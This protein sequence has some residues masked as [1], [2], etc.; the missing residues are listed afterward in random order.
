MSKFSL[1][2]SLLVAFGGAGGMLAA[3]EA[4]PLG[5]FKI[6]AGTLGGDTKKSLDFGATFSFAV[7]G[8]YALSERGALVGELG[9]RYFPGANNLVS[10]IPVSVPATGVNPTSYESRNRLTDAKG[11]QVTGLYRFEVVPRTA[12]IQ[13]GLRIG[14]NKTTETDTGT[15]LVTDG[16]AITNTGS[17][18]NTHILAVNTIA[19]RQE[20]K[21]LAP[22]LVAGAGYRFLN[23]YATEINLFT[24]RIETASSGAKNG[25]AAEVVFSVQF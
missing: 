17:I 4:P 14:L 6:G 5:A 2:A 23:R 15:Q 22:G 24:T 12:Y 21:S 10:F 19:S 20:K 7:E 16:T 18:T 8:S 3:Q 25:F 11:F 9:Y 1:L 13:A